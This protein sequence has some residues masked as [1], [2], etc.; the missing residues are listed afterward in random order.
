MAL[1]EYFSNSQFDVIYASTLKRAHQTAIEVHKQQPTP[2]PP[3]ITSP[4][5]REQ[6]FGEAEGKPWTMTSDPNKSVA[7]LLAEG[8]YPVLVH[9]HDKFPG[10]ES[11]DDLRMRAHKAVQEIIMPHIWEAA[12]EGKKGVHLAIVSHGLCISEVRTTF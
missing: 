2:Q 11:L 8:K 1:G 12:Q 4:D 10:G 7:Q 6:G 9:R 5:L 3:L